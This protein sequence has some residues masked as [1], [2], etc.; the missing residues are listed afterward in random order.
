MNRASLCA[1]R[2][3]FAL[4]QPRAASPRAA[5]GGGRLTHRGHPSFNVAGIRPEAYPRKVSRIRASFHARKVPD[6]PR[7][8]FR[9]STGLRSGY[10]PVNP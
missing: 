9:L 4:P 2:A 5:G 10:A 3:G 8:V 6:L 7:K 1:A